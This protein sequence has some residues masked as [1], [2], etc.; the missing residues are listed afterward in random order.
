[1]GKRIYI[2]E[3]LEL[4][5]Y[6]KQIVTDV[7]YLNLSN[8]VKE[9]FTAN[10]SSVVPSLLKDHEIDY[11][12]CFLT[13]YFEDIISGTNIWKVFTN[14]H[15]Q[16]YQKRLPFY[17]T[18]E[19]DEEEIN[20]QDVSFLIWYFLNTVQEIKFIAPYNDFI[21]STALEIMDIF[22]QAWEYAPENKVLKSYYQINEKNPDFYIC[23]NLIDSIL[24]KSY[25]FHPD[26]L[27]SLSDKENEL[28]EALKDEDAGRIIAL[29][30]EN[31]DNAAHHYS[32]R[33]LGLKGK[34]WA[35]EILGKDH[36]LY[37]VFINQS[38]K[39]SGHFL[40]KGQ[41][42]DYV[43]IEHIASGKRFELTKKSFD[44]SKSLAKI[45]TILTIGIVQWENEWWFSGVY[46]TQEFDPGLIVREQNS[47]KSRMA[48][49]FLDHPKKE[50]HKLLKLQHEAFLKYNSGSI[51]KFL[52]TEKVESFFK[53]YLDFYNNSLKIPE[54]E[55]EEATKRIKK[56][57]F[58]K[59]NNDF[60]FSDKGDSA[61]LFFNPKSGLEIAFG[62]NSA[63]PLPD[64]PYFREE[65]S[66]EHILR[67]FM[68]ESIST[69]LAMFCVNTCKNKLHFFTKDLGKLYLADID[70]LLRFWKKGNYHTKPSITLT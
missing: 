12:S 35:A 23:R 10:K 57:G 28:I 36:P 9:V 21:F 46:T 13:S 17:P 56:Q 25:L 47:M 39:I 70:F 34:E 15:N 40:Y 69:E 42:S 8:A 65:N 19:Y 43:F 2:R 58:P 62:V 24:F 49:N 1:M 50:I 44:S 64:N 63:F 6:E 30:N 11:L 38:Q 61:L 20:V 33:L 55:K 5:P 32:T 59:R 52:P 68:D 16:L 67:L 3:W 31:R 45:D 18:E 53:G 54:K 29:L 4:K 51:I 37:S 27:Q 14:I 22:D 7:F 26:T 41:D 66:E 60:D 48:V